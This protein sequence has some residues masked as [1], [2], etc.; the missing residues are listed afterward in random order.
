MPL[1]AYW[2]THV[3]QYS[4]SVHFDRDA[5]TSVIGYLYGL[6]HVNFGPA[7]AADCEGPGGSVPTLENPLVAKEYKM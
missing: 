6:R 1:L 4:F 2:G 5:A 3:G 7:T